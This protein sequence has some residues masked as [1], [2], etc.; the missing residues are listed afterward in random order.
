MY[1]SGVFV[2]TPF[3]YVCAFI[4]LSLVS[5]QSSCIAKQAAVSLSVTAPFREEEVQL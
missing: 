4:L 2:Y 5:E 1:V 3:L